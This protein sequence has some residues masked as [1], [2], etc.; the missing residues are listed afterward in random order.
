MFEISQDLVVFINIGLI[1]YF[2][3]TLF[4]CF[5]KGFIR[6][7]L[8]IMR[9]VI[10]FL[11]A[12]IFSGPLANVIP[13]INYDQN[14][15]SGVLFLLIKKS[16]NQVVWFGI[17]F[18]M[19]LIILWLVTRIL[20]FSF[21]LAFLGIFNNIL[22]LILGFGICFIKANIILIILYSP[23]FKNGNLIA[24]K[25]ILSSVASSFSYIEKYV[26]FSQVKRDLIN[27]HSSASP[28]YLK[29]LLNKVGLSEEQ[30]TKILKEYIHE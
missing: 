5:K 4:V 18:I 21:R 20:D 29:E 11:L 27:N 13:L 25:S 8:G 30:I 22:G 16:L 1:I 10:A 15:V 2:L 3:F 7:L 19:S 12:Y 23:L 17:V 26:D 6:S 14:D 28:D 9:Y 24:E